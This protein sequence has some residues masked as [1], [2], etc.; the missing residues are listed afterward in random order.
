MRAGCCGILMTVL[1]VPA[2]SAQSAGGLQFADVGQLAEI[3]AVA[4]DEQEL[5][6]RIR[7]QLKA[8]TPKTEK[9]GNVYVTVGRGA[10]HPL[11]VPA[12]AEPGASLS[13]ITPDG[14]L[15]VPRPPHAS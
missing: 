3:P 6:S 8:F 9:F 10:P 5:S 11:L 2:A 7:E 12:I 1:T 14:F 15:R 13:R 4:G